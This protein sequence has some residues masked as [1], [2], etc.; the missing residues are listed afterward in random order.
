MCNIFVKTSFCDA[1][2]LAFTKNVFQ[3]PGQVR[4][5]REACIRY[6]CWNNVLTDELLVGCTPTV[7]KG[8]EGLPGGKF[9]EAGPQLGGGKFPG[10]GSGIGV[11][12]SGSS[13]GGPSFHKSTSEGGD[14]SSPSLLTNQQQAA[15]ASGAQS[16]G[17]S[18]ALLGSVTE[19]DNGVKTQHVDVENTKAYNAAQ[20]QF[21]GKSGYT[22][23]EMKS[24]KDHGLTAVS[25]DG[26]ASLFHDASAVV[27]TETE[28]DLQEG[29]VMSKVKSD[30]LAASNAAAETAAA[31]AAAV[32]GE[33]AICIDE[34]GQE[35]KFGESWVYK[36]N[37]CETC[38][39]YDT[40]DIRCV[41]KA[42]DPYPECPPGH[43]VVEEKTDDCCIVYRIVKDT[44]DVS[45]CEFLP[46]T[47]D[48]TEDLAAYPIDDCCSS[49]ECIC[50]PSRCPDLG[51]PACPEGSV[52]V[53]VEQ[54]QCCQVG[55]CVRIDATGGAATGASV[56]TTVGGV[57]VAH[58]TEKLPEDSAAVAAESLS[59][60]AGAGAS[61][62][63]TP[64]GNALRIAEESSLCVDEDGVERKFGE[65]WN[66]KSDPCEI[67]S[68][69]DVNDVQCRREVCDPYP[70]Q[71]N[72]KQIVEEK[73][74]TCCY[75]YRYVDVACDP[76]LCEYQ[77]TICSTF[78]TLV[79]YDIDGCCSTYECV[80]DEAKCFELGHPPCPEGS[81]RII[82]DQDA[83]CPAAKC[84]FIDA[85]ASA[86]AEAIDSIAKASVF[87]E[88]SDAPAQ[89]AIVDLLLSDDAASLVS[90]VAADTQK[91]KLDLSKD[92]RKGSTSVTPFVSGETVLGSTSLAH[93][94]S[95]AG[96]LKS[97]SLGLSSA[98]SD[99]G[100][101]SGVNNGESSLIPAISTS[102]TSKDSFG[103]G[104]AGLSSSASS[105]DVGVPES[106][107]LEVVTEASAC[108]DENGQS[109][110]LGEQWFVDCNVFT[111]IDI[112]NVEKSVKTCEPT[113]PAKEGYKIVED[114]SDSCCVTYRVVPDECEPSM[115]QFSPPKCKFNEIL[116]TIPMDKCCATYQ[117][118]CDKNLC[119]AVADL[120]CPD[121]STRQVI[122]P[123]VCCP[124]GKCVKAEALQ[125]E[126]E[127]F[128]EAGTAVQQ[129]GSLL[130]AASEESESVSTLANLGASAQTEALA[131]STSGGRLEQLA[132]ATEKPMCVDEQGYSR[133]Y[134][135]TWSEYGA[136]CTL[137][138]CT[139]S[140]NIDCK[141]KTCDSYPMAPEGYVVVEEKEDDCCYVYR[142]VPENCDVTS[143]AESPMICNHYEDLV[144]YA[145]DACC[146]TYECTCNKAKCPALGNPLCRDG[147][148]RV[149]LEDGTCC[150]VAKCITR[151][152]TQSQS[153][154]GSGILLGGTS[155]ITELHEGDESGKATKGK[156]A[157]GTEAAGLSAAAGAQR[158]G[159]YNDGGK[160]AGKANK[161]IF[162]TGDT[163]IGA[164]AG[165]LSGGQ[166]GY[167]P[168]VYDG[169][170]Y[171]DGDAE[172]KSGNVIGG[173]TFK[174]YADSGDESDGLTSLA[175]KGDY[176]AAGKGLATGDQD[177]GA[178][179]DDKDFGGDAT[180]TMFTTGD[181]MIGAGALGGAGNK[182]GGFGLS[183]VGFGTGSALGSGDTGILSGGV[184]AAFSGIADDALGASLSAGLSSGASTHGNAASNVGSSLRV[185]P[186]ASFCVDS[187]GREKLFGDSWLDY[188][189]PCR[190][191]TCVDVEDV[192]YVWLYFS[193]S[194]FL[195]YFI[196]ET[197][198]CY[199]VKG[200]KLLKSF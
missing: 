138:T 95:E 4:N 15:A 20:A 30:Q 6:Y 72:G 94:N 116:K 130:S 8:S 140:K 173:S 121:G 166:H 88:A 156:T 69:S 47:C 127:A 146:A 98:V 197:F 178:Y 76:S 48:S 150:P 102:D 61:G 103:V 106:T 32:V 14:A 188:E 165:G 84:V 120:P 90:A 67:C 155:L 151:H 31:L 21:N 154:I 189:D 159:F 75:T 59:D 60:A 142:T 196:F 1:I 7:G 49:Y 144:T 143:C 105:G 125:Q 58:A 81:K 53:V 185:L 200:K 115:C 40:A 137:C 139:D 17:A 128:G 179:I 78:Q 147:S 186:E 89:T 187:A 70:G 168:G 171:F 27:Q 170:G 55:K 198:R 63:S 82:L 50:N 117:C 36:N 129:T 157:A 85:K 41:E 2:F 23:D 66:K 33:G 148:E 62:A 180:K 194:R 136:A 163:T 131:G 92:S 3:Q 113:P 174:T 176:L 162:Q 28:S 183:N 34:N 45:T 96:A 44:C 39:C 161:A 184:S 145:I 104:T 101:L 111:C 37:A 153:G 100:A 18:D 43:Y 160:K 114:F 167:Y 13:L 16:A 122:E 118:V 158:Q 79:T 123:H 24:V 190:L 135:E 57:A 80:C 77:P 109:R 181:T 164:G 191:C 42:C 193:R 195:T 149:V 26:T 64:S 172:A 107:G 25:S 9:G 133:M 56:G 87:Q 86:N 51:D 91:G 177:S 119:P 112:E 169:K 199:N 11:T 126:V 93:A 71:I 10:S 175:G 132:I 108:Y 182:F 83:C 97:D 141:P 65:C 110:T 124:V 35:R 29:S 73:T 152:G 99:A 52:R 54:G 192:R 12:G 134:G 68:C 22:D 38:S 74:T 19:E 5:D 46:P